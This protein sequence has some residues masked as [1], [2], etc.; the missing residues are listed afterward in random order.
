MA[1]WEHRRARMKKKILGRAFLTVAS[2]FY[3][4]A[5]IARRKLYELGL[6]KSKRLDAKVV[7]IGNLTTGGT[8]KT[9]AVLLA[10]QT[11]RKHDV[12]TAILSRGYGGALAKRKEVVTLLDNDPPH[13]TECGDEPW[14]M[15]QAL[16]GQ[17]VPILVCPDRGKAGE[18]AVTFYHSKVVILDDGFQHLKLKRDLDIVLIN[19][20]DPFAGGHVLPLGN[21]REPVSALSRAGLVLLT[22]VDLVE[23][24]AIEKIKETVKTVNP[25][26]PILES[27][28]KADFL[29]DVRTDKKLKLETLEGK[30]VVTVCGIADPTS[31]EGQLARIGA[32]VKQRWRY[33]D[34][35]PYRT[36]E[37]RSIEELRHGAPIVTTL[38]DFTRFPE[39]WAETLTGDVY[40]L[41][42][43]LDIIKGRNQFS[44]ALLSLAGHSE[45]AAVEQ[46]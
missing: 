23:P 41:A 34:H 28:H 25:K 22:H 30:G 18:Q 36:R 8:G 5:M 37:L 33:P 2:L 29:L 31:F 24:A 12:P 3:A 13:W 38:K 14:M 46:A 1:N 42:I 7:C 16:A 26:A 4:A 15:H 45:A 35:H 43:K 39:K 17:E 27:Q 44:H 9:P 6:L 32:K 20:A 40:V 21:L 19:A 11:L 10:A